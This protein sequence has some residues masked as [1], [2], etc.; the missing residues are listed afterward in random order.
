MRK[1]IVIV[2]LT[3]FCFFSC[4]KGGDNVP[5][6]LVD[7]TGQIF[8]P[9][10]NRLSNGGPP[11][12]IPNYGIA[13]LVIYKTVQGNYRAY[14]RCS[15]FQPEKK[16]AVNVDDTGLVLVDPCSGS[17]FSLE[18]GTPVKAPATHALRSYRVE[19]TQF[20]IHVVN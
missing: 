13:G 1:L 17:K 2:I 19:S 3:G 18:D 10:L 8:S 14:D 9:P 5:S 4:G 7:Y 12:F 16:C 20:T 11:V 6:V 15:S